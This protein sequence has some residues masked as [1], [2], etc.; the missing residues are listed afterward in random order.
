MTGTAVEAV[1]V[2][3][4][5][6]QGVRALPLDAARSAAGRAVIP[7]GRPALEG[8][9]FRRATRECLLG[10]AAVDALLRASETSREGVK[11]SSTALIYVTGCAHG[12]TNHAWVVVPPARPRAGPGPLPL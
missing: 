10:V 4:G 3:T 8:E 11:G 1:S 9:R 12:A 5:W 2:L 7:L 6:G